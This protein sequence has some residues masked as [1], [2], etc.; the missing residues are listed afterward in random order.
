MLCG[1]KLGHYFS[2]SK[3]KNSRWETRGGGEAG[4]TKEEEEK[5]GRVVEKKIGGRVRKMYIKIGRKTR[6]E[7]RI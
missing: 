7:E 4:Y 6:C 5:T 1:G 2:D 3:A